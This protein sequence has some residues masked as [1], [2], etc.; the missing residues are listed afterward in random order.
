[1]GTCSL[2]LPRVIVKRKQA[3]GHPSFSNS[4]RPSPIPGLRP[5]AVVSKIFVASSPPC[6]GRKCTRFA[7]CQQLS[8]VQWRDLPR[9][10]HSLNGDG[11]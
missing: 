9:S 11:G 8:P 7:R 6:N 10:T 1:M 3:G 4:S 5:D 2:P